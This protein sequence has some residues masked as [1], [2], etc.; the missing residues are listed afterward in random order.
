MASV[1]TIKILV[2]EPIDITAIARARNIM[3]HAQ[4]NDSNKIVDWTVEDSQKVNDALADSICNDTYDSG[5]AF[6]DW[7]IYSASEA[8]FSGDSAG[9]WSNTFGWTTQDLATRFG[10]QMV[11]LPMSRGNDAMS[12][13]AKSLIA[14]LQAA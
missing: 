5:D 6:S 2:D 9:F 8:Q 13:Q 11:N 12:I 4:R 3:L 7:M 1:V 14:D 10:S